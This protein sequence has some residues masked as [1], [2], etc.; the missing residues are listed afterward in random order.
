MSQGKEVYILRG[1]PGSGK[2]TFARITQRAAEQKHKTARVYSADQYM[3]DGVGNYRFSQDKLIG[4]H[5]QCQAAFVRGLTDPDIR[6]L[7][8]DNTHCRRDEMLFY[9]LM[10][11]HFEAVVTVVSL[12]DGGCDDLTLA[13]RNTHRVPMDKIENM[14]AIYEK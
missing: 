2:T 8:V 5:A 13:Y 11:Y 10:S 6:V 14:R 12:F 7:I 1:L 4:A 9:Q 3:V